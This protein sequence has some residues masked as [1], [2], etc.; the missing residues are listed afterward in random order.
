MLR[1]ALAGAEKVRDEDLIDVMRSAS[2]ALRAIR[3]QTVIMKLPD[4]QLC[5]EDNLGSE[6]RQLC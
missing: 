2:A 1:E 4:G 3:H 5:Y 6:T